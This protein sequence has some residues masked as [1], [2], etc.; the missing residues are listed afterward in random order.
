MLV[1]ERYEHARERGA[2]IYAEIIG[3]H[4]L[5]E[6]HHVTGLDSESE[7]LTRLIEMT[8][9]KSQLASEQ[10]GYINAHATGTEQNDLAEMRAIRQVFGDQTS[11]LLVSGTKSMLGHMINAAGAVELVVT[12][13]AMRDGFAPPTINV[14]DPDPECQ[15]DCLP[16]FG[17]LDRFQHALKLSVAFGGHLVA[18]AL[19]RW[20]DPLTGYAYPD[21]ATF[22]RR[23]A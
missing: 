3:G 14:E 7:V 16:Q 18:I 23:A 6:A 17:K 8:L 1:L 11:S 4:M 21:E 9:E 12:A 20:N 5:G 2:R 15:F 10:V 13:L 22:V 19:R